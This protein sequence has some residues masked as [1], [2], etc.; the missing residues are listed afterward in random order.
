MPDWPAR[1]QSDRFKDY[2]TSVIRERLPTH[3]SNEIFWLNANEMRVFEH[4]YHE[5]Q[6]LKSELKSSKAHSIK[7]KSAAFKVYQQIIE[8]KKSN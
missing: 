7:M 8:I 6:N 5:W 3:I 1:F 2:V 4:K